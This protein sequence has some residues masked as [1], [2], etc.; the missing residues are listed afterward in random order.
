MVSGAGA[1][2]LSA[3]GNLAHAV[4]GFLD[5]DADGIVRKQVLYQFRPF[6]QAEVAA[7]GIVVKTEVH[8]L[9]K[10]LDAVKVEMI[11]GPYVGTVFVDD[12]EGGA[13]YGI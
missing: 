8:D 1:R 10:F 12:G 7:I 9:S 6:H 4:V 11:D 5:V 2:S 3:Y 13:C